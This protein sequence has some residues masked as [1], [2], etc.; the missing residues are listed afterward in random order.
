MFKTDRIKARQAVLGLAV[1]WHANLPEREALHSS[2]DGAFCLGSVLDVLVFFGII[3]YPA[4]MT[5]ATRHRHHPI[6]AWQGGPSH[7]A[8]ALEN[9]QQF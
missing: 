4:C 1:L 5:W 2:I 6:F 3:S 8:S 7:V 9:D